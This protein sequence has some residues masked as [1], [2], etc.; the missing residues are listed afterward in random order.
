M[1][2]YRLPDWLGGHECFSPTRIDDLFTRVDVVSADGD[3]GPMT[4]PT[5]W[6]VVVKPPSI[7]DPIRLPLE[8]RLLQLKDHPAVTLVLTA[9]GHDSA[10]DLTMLGDDGHE[11]IQKGR[12]DPDD[13][14]HLAQA[15]WQLRQRTTGTAS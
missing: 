5:D 13:L 10:A 9:V 11:G 8:L 3:P 7:D 12:L 4:V 15:A 2:T 14:L 6:L 1:I